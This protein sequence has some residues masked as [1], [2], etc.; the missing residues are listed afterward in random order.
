MSGEKYK[1]LKK[2]IKQK[3]KKIKDYE[4]SDN[5]LAAL[6]FIITAVLGAR[7]GSYLRIFVF[8]HEEKE[9]NKK[10]E[11]DYY[12]LKEEPEL[13]EWGSGR[14]PDNESKWP[15]DPRAGAGAPPT[16][17]LF[18]K[19]NKSKRNKK[20]A[21]S[22][23]LGGGLG[24]G[25][26]FYL[27]N[28]LYSKI[29]EDEK[30]SK[31]EVERNDKKLE[32]N[33]KR[34]MSIDEQKESDAP[35]SVS[36]TALKKIEF[37]KEFIRKHFNKMISL[38]DEEDFKIKSDLGDTRL[39]EQGDFDRAMGELVRTKLKLKEDKKKIKKKK[40]WF[41][42]NKDANEKI[43]IIKE[44]IK[45]NEKQSQQIENFYDNYF[46]QKEKRLTKKKLIEILSGKEGID[47]D[48]D[49]DYLKYYSY[50]EL[51]KMYEEIMEKQKEISLV[52]DSYDDPDQEVMLFGKKKRR[53]K[54]IPASLKKKCKRLKIRLTLKKGGKRVYK[55]EA[56]LKKQCKKADK[57]RKK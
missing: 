46:K 5:K 57:R 55:S 39:Q 45:E 14:P 35:E 3:I 28:K 31:E 53:K 15:D 19:K 16:V 6:V 50:S 2:E 32:A 4:I 29:H 8:N 48:K 22:A 25:T 44:Q 17:R 9:R 43:G 36:K 42:R 20:I 38:K 34:L 30:K 41:S 24:V 40:K 49:K 11:K 56:M 51:Y 26:G 7:I 18:G 12:S 52:L 21:L 37:N 27:R 33:L 54:K 1:E 47:K 10:K 23:V 13:E